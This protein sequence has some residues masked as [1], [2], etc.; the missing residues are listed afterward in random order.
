[1]VAEI[2]NGRALANQVIAAVKAEAP[3][4]KRPPGLAVILAGDDPASHLYVNMKAK[5][6]REIGFVAELIL[7]PADV[8]E[9]RVSRRG[10]RAQPPGRYRRRPGPGPPA[11]AD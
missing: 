1:M 7:L 5:L 9:D 10:R 6:A 4:L 8:E 2:I 3:Q 11:A